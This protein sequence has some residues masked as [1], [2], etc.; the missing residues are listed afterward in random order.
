MIGPGQKV[1]NTDGYYDVSPSTMSVFWGFR[2]LE[3]DPAKVQQL[4]DAL[5][6]YP[7]SRKHNPG[8]VRFVDVKGKVWLRTQPR[9][10][11]YWQVL[12][13]IIDS[14]PVQERQGFFLAMIKPLRRPGRSAASM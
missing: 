11:A 4:L 1:D 13:D 8:K 12:A 14:E 9:G 10:L 3:S 5:K 6:I 2:A 7:L